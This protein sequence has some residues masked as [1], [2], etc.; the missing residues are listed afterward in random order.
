MPKA[1]PTEAVISTASGFLLCDIGEVYKVS[2]YMAG[3]PVWTHQL[4][5]VGREIAGVIRA[6]HPELAA[7]LDECQQI[8][9]ENYAEMR[10]RFIARH[11]P[12][13]EVSPMT[14][15]QHESRAP[16]SELAEIVPP[17]RIIPVVR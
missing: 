10:D 13:I 14:T 1:F 5:R 11:G 8:T 4:P 16:I 3:E 6:R 2:E 12:T 9:P 17:D 15:D 7:T